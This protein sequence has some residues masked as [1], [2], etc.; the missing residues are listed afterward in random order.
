MDFSTS[1]EFFVNMKHIPD[2]SSQEYDAFFQNELDKIE[3]GFTV[4]GV[5]IDGWLYWH[6]NH[7]KINIDFEEN[8]IIKR[9]L[10]TPY[11]R[12]NEWTI[13]EYRKKALEA[14]KGLVV[15]GSRRIAK[16]EWSS[17]IIARSA[18]IFQGSENVIAAGNGPDLKLLADKID[19]GLSNVHPYFIWYR[20]ENDWKKQVTL[21]YKEKAGGIRRAFS[22]I[23]PRNL[24]D[25]N[26]TEA[27]AGIT[28]YELIFEEIGKYPFLRCLEAAIPAL[29][30]P[31]GWRA[32]P[33]FIGTGGA[34]EKG[35]DA[36]SLFNDPEAYNFLAVEVKDEP[37]K[38]GLF[39]PGTYRME[40]KQDCKL[41]EWLETE[42]GI[43]V[44]K[45]SEIYNLHF[46]YSDVEKAKKTILEEREKAKRANNQ[47]AYLKAVMYYPLTPAECF[48]TASHNMF[49]PEN[50]RI[51]KQKVL[52][53]EIKG[54]N[55]FLEHDGEKIVP[56]NTDK[57]PIT[58]YPHKPNADKDCPIIVW[59]APIPNAPRGLYVC[60]VDSFKESESKYS[61]S[62]GAVYIF[63]RIHSITDEKF[64][65]MI[66]A[67]YVAKPAS[68]DKWN[69]Q[70]R[71]LIKWYNAIALV[72]NDELSF[73]DYMKAQGDSMYLAKTPQFARQEMPNSNTLNR[74]YGVSRSNARMRE[75]L[76]GLLKRYLLHTVS[77]EKDDQGSIIKEKLGIAQI[78]DLGLLD[79][80]IKFDPDR[81]VDRIVAFELALAMANE[82]DPISKI[83]SVEDDPRRIHFFNKEK[84]KSS[85]IFSKSNTYY[86][87][88]KIKNLFK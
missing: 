58:E 84:Q 30:S 86:R 12:D 64:Q 56:K 65:D 16:S 49:N 48:L 52:D 69:E 60:G 8:K 1:Q 83:T 37:K 36:E 62:L 41:G 9:Q 29:T 82:L 15:V 51:Q 2:P 68:K 44:P 31:Y 71:L 34:F 55:I 11:L 13:A 4:N 78:F 77:R 54:A 73:I 43:T 25:G 27:V 67:S 47:E 66:V 14:K 32:S 46:Q 6:T 35:S 24:D 87:K 21:G 70:A 72:E 53:N 40:A 57:Q 22:S 81:N 59:E 18:T 10:L 7:W 17:S 42:K 80:I 38:Y 63:K 45:N 28:A 39:I 5:Y 85:G 61:D 79:E 74:E 26:N 50:A 19:R 23:F 75:F 20:V 76:H 33:F 3:N 88:D